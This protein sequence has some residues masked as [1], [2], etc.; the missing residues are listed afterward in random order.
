[1]LGGVKRAGKEKRKEKK[2][3][4]CGVIALP[5][6][7][8]F[9]ERVRCEEGWHGSVDGL[10]PGGTQAQTNQRFKIDRTETNHCRGTS[11]SLYKSQRRASQKGRNVR[12]GKQ[13]S[14]IGTYRTA[15]FDTRFSSPALVAFDVKKK[16][17]ICSLAIC[18][19]EMRCIREEH[20]SHVPCV[21]P[22]KVRAA[23]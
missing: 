4:D 6:P 11:A 23:D 21:I 10:T 12:R 16:K 7:L 2:E 5:P 9:P 8:S 18:R 1:M 17:K 20:G 3:G 14:H 15:T 19:N 13:E 22:V